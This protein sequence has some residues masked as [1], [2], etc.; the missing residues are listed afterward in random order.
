M[1]LARGASTDKSSAPDKGPGVPPSANRLARFRPD[2]RQTILS[3]PHADQWFFFSSSWS[4]SVTP[5]IFINI[6]ERRV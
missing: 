5:F 3:S 6:L 2:Y 4:F 1:T